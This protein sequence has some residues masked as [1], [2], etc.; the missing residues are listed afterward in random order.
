M[1]GIYGVISF[2]TA[3]A[4]S[5]AVHTSHRTHRYALQLPVLYRAEGE[6]HWHIGVT[7]NVSPTS[8]LIAGDMPAASADTIDVVIEVSPR[9]GCLTG[10][11]R[12]S[13]LAESSATP[14][15]AFA[16]TVP[17]FSLEHRPGSLASL[18]RL[19]QEC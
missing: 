1:G 13:R 4:L 6:A 17:H 15:A 11:G 3:L 8:V 16:I 14:D 5:A 12:V 18:V 19:D 7:V 2:G 10:H 9:A